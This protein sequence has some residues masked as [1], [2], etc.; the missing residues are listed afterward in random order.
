MFKLL[1][2]MFCCLEIYIRIVHFDLEFKFPII[3]KFSEIVYGGFSSQP[4]L[5]CFCA[6]E[7]CFAIFLNSWYEPPS[8]LISMTVLP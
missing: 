1:T 2:G 7:Y 5:V 6:L 4:F 8:V 3:I